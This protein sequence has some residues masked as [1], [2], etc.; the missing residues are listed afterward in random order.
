[1]EIIAYLDDNREWTK[2]DIDAENLSC[3]N[4]AFA[5]IVDGKIQRSLKKINLINQ[6]KKKAP[7]L[8]S[9]ISVGGWSADGFSDAVLTE[10]SRM[11]LI[12]SVLKYI[13]KYDFDG[14]DLDWEYPKVDL[15]GIAARNEDA[16]NLLLLLEELRNELDKLEEKNKKKYL[17]TIAVG[18][19]FELLETTA[20][21]NGHEYAEYID[22]INIM[23]YDMRGSFT[24]VTGHH[25]NLYPY[26]QQE[27]LS[28]SESVDYLMSKGIP[29]NKLVIGAAFY[30]RVW[31]GV[32]S[33]KNNGLMQYAEKTGCKAL[34]HNEIQELIKKYPD[35]V[36]V[37]KVAKSPYYFDGKT[38]ISFENPYSL[39]EKV[40]YVKE[41]NLRGIMYWEHSLDRSGELVKAIVEK[42]KE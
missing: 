7:R 21:K 6:L 5:D 20:T 12:E 8:K 14:I 3:I 27:K 38:F 23:T 31:E 11:I 32:T 10:K 19:S 9:C 36:F 33:N 35:S 18:A 34:D 15:A 4:Y 2:E 39:Q 22:Y 42:A 41:K 25:A 16:E 13:E 24:N 30:G 1:M 17:L 29:A 40:Q 28:A 26:D 37:D